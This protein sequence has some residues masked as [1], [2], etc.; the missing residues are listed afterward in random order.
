MNF[1]FR[2]VDRDGINHPTSKKTNINVPNIRN[3]IYSLKSILNN[4][5]T[6]FCLVLLITTPAFSLSTFA[7]S[8]ASNSNDN[9]SRSTI[10]NSTTMSSDAFLNGVD[11]VTN[12]GPVRNIIL[13][14]GD[15]WV[16]QKLL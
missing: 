6:M 15:G 16:I 2:R 12:E 4:Y 10:L 8:N 11:N 1:S 9:G 7:T 13:L 14:I 3:N 5:M